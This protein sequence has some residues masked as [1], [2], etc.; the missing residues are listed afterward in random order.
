[1]ENAEQVHTFGVDVKTKSNLLIRRWLIFCY[2]HKLQHEEY[3]I[4]P[5]NPSSVENTSL[6]RMIFGIYGNFFPMFFRPIYVF[7]WISL[8]D[9]FNWFDMRMIFVFS[10]LLNSN[11]LLLWGC[12]INHFVWCWD[13]KYFRFIVV[14][15]VGEKSNMSLGK[16]PVHLATNAQQKSIENHF[17]VLSE[18]VHVDAQRLVYMKQVLLLYILFNFQQKN[19]SNSFLRDTETMNKG[20]GLDAYLKHNLSQ[21]K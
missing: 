20:L 8:H 19:P 9:K 16:I 13:R 17:Q 4:F 18:M 11:V 21:R 1:M 10:H 5:L 3:W 2:Y 14:G 6:S 7:I 15:F 12:S